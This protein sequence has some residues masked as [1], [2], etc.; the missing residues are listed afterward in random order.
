MVSENDM[1]NILVYDGS[2]FTDALL[3]DIPIRNNSRPQSVVTTS[4]SLFVAFKA[5]PYTNTLVYIRITAGLTKKYDLNITGSSIVDN[6]G[7]GVA[8]E[9]IKSSVYIHQTSVS[10]N[11]HIAGKN[12]K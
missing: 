4:N 11:K 9:N 7:R 3:V 8:V 1:A 6:N 5:K 10:N 2:Y 12:D